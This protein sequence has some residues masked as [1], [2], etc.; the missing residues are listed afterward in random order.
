M[1]VADG[2]AVHG[3]RRNGNCSSKQVE[4]FFT[5]HVDKCERGGKMTVELK[6]FIKNDFATLVS[7]VFCFG[8]ESLFGLSLLK[9]LNGHKAGAVD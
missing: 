2:A 8:S 1:Q 7:L 5:E 3:G 9:K 4:A 6:S